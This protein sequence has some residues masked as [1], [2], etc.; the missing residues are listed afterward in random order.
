MAMTGNLYPSV[1]SQ[2]INSF[3]VPSDNRIAVTITAPGGSLAASTFPASMLSTPI[4]SYHAFD[5]RLDMTLQ[6][7]A[8]ASTIRILFM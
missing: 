3:A 6:S 7:D 8:E 4:G 1:F 5:N 2:L